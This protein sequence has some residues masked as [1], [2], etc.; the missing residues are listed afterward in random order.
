MQAPLRLLL[1]LRPT[2]APAL[3]VAVAA[4]TVVFAST[5]FILPAV[6]DEY[7]VSTGRAGLISATQ[8]GG[9]V[10]AS[11]IGGRFLKPVR[12]VFIAGTLLGVLANLASAIAPTFE[13]LAAIR[14]LS[15]ISL[16]LAAWFAWQ[17][18]FGD[19]G[20]VGDVAV[21]GPLVGMVVAPTVAALI[22]TIGVNGVFAVLGVVSAAPLVFVSG[23]GS[24]DEL[25]PHRTRHAATMAARAILLALAIVTVG[26]SSVFVY[27]VAIGTEAN[28]MTALT[29][30]LIYSANA[31]AA[32]PAAKWYGPRGPAG[33][34]F[35]CTAVCAF[36]IAGV[37]NPIVFSVALVAW[38]FVF[39]MGVPAAF[40]LLAA[41]SNFPE[42][43]AGDAQAVMALG[44]VFG[45]L[46]GGVFIGAGAYIGLA[47]TSAAILMVAAG[48]LLF[49]DRRRF[50]V[51]G[52]NGR[53]VVRRGG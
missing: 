1:A 50:L 46:L 9:F 15:G 24:H 49:V 39:F 38:G 32:I 52:A 48:T 11:W 47:F 42:E 45:P 33:I 4:S 2:V 40:G 25:R 53:G 12:S 35:V 51:S 10:A 36:S 3:L 37:R 13:V 6:A 18:A 22:E 31:I 23:V 29:V 28:G 7:G 43:R 27:G 21:V 44:R 16:G 5:P 30:S 41:R 8:L 34:W 19:D 26:G 17:D 20:K 14:L